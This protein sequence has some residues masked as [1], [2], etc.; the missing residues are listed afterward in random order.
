MD[1]KSI[2]LLKAGA[3]ASLISAIEVLR[4]FAGIEQN[5]LQQILESSCFIALILGG[6]WFEITG[7][8]TV[9]LGLSAIAAFN[10]FRAPAMNCPQYAQIPFYFAAGIL[11]GYFASAQRKARE[12]LEKSG[13]DMA[14]AYKE[15]NETFNQLRHSDRLTSLARLSAGIA[16]EVRNPLASIL[17]AVEILGEGAS[18]SDPKLEFAQIAR[19]EIARLEKLTR[20]IVQFS[21][22]SPPQKFKTDPQEIIEEACRSIAEQ[23]RKQNIEIVKRCDQSPAT[24]MVDTEQIRVAAINMLLSSLHAQYD[25]NVVISCKTQGNEWTAS[26]QCPGHSIPKDKLD[27]VFDPFYSIKGESGG[28]GLS[29][30]HQLIRSNGGRIWAES[31]PELGA[32]FIFSFPLQ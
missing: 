10:S 13:T 6:A 21:K 22:P 16:H 3:I 32:C 19:K 25:G 7:G 28:L 14:A 15:L 8:L 17:G 23:A 29:I 1:A 11:A 26:I 30:A 27:R 20:D 31:Q 12:S 2:R 18:P 5:W 24:I 4:Y 9:A